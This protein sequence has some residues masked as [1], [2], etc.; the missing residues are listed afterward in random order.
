M[1]VVD[2]HGGTASSWDRMQL[3]TGGVAAGGERMGC[4]GVK[5]LTAHTRASLLSALFP[6]FPSAGLG[7]ALCVDTAGL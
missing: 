1:A 4:L 5:S 6:R 2:D 7:P 3:G